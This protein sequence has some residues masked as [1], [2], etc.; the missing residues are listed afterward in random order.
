M[1]LKKTLAFLLPAAALLAGVILVAQTDVDPDGDGIPDVFELFFGLTGDAA[2]PAADPD[3]DG[4]DNAAEKTVWTDPLNADTDFDGF[5]DGLDADPVSRA[6]Y[7]WGDPRFTYGETNA[8]T[9]PLWAGNGVALGG[10]HAEYPGYSHAWVLEPE[11]GCLLMPVDRLVQS[12]DLWIAVSANADGVMAVDMLD[13]DLMAV[14]PAISL[15]SAGDTWFTNRIPLSSYPGARTL[16]LHV[17]QGVAHVFASML[18]VDT[19]NNGFDDAQDAQL[20]GLTGSPL[21]DMTPAPLSGSAPSA[22]TNATLALSPFV[23]SL[24]D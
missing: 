2:D 6:A 9:R 5:P 3:S 24:G 16:S 8:Y 11:L 12:N 17:T 23:W 10:S 15:A 21:A 13:S 7:L 19:D 14:A 22:S 18:Y 4:M 20:A 1:K